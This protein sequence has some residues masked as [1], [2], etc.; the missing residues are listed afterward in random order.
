M[1]WEIVKREDK[2]VGADQPYISIAPSR[3]TFNATLSR[4]LQLDPSKRVTIGVDSEER[5]LGFEFHTEKREDSLA[6]TFQGGSARGA[7]G[8]SVFCSAVGVV[9][10]YDWVKSVASQKSVQ[11]RRFTP[12]KEGRYWAI[13]LYPA[14]EIKRSRESANI[15]S[16]A[17]GIYRYIREGGEIVYI[18]QGQIR[19]RLEAR[20]REDWDFV[21]VEYSIIEDPDKRLEW[22]DFWIERFK[23]ANDGKLP[24]YNRISGRGRKD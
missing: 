5:K 11:E 14:F 10:L 23:K 2:L 22:E 6:L 8:Q 3:F 1:P 20:G 17:D 13:Q 19:Q 21:A 4:Q 7:K 15:P 24:I 16:D 12:Q 9:K 18:G